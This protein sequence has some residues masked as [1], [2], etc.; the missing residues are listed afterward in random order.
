MRSNAGGLWIAFI[1]WFLLEAARAHYAQSQLAAMLRGLRVADVMARDCAMVDAD[2]TLRHFVDGE[3]LRLS[4]RCFAV[5][6][7][8]QVVGLI[9]PDDVRQIARDRWEHTTVSD[10]MRP[11]ESLH[12]L[13]PD[14]PAAEALTVMGRENLNQL[15]V[16]A[17]GHLEGVVTRSYLA[18]VLHLRSEFQT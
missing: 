15:P 12:P 2:E 6:R 18:H 10:A 17:Q 11:L 7:N 13:D 1:G 8:G 9:T 5:S 14:V 3:L 16:V 4:A